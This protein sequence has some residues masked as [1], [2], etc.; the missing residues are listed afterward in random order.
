MIDNQNSPAPTV[1]PVNEY[2]YQVFCVNSPDPIIITDSGCRILYVNPAFV[3]LTGF[4]LREL[5]DCL[6]PFPFQVRDGTTN[7]GLLSAD[8]QSQSKEQIWKKKDGELIRVETNPVP[9][10]ENGV[11]KYV[12]CLWKDITERKTLK[13][14]LQVSEEKLSNMLNAIPIPIAIAA[15][16]SGIIE[17]VNKSFLKAGGYT[18]NEI[19][20]RSGNDLNWNDA[21]TH[22]RAVAKLMKK[23]HFEAE[24]IRLY[25]REGELR[26]SLLCA[27]IVEFGGKQYMLS[28][29]IDIT[30]RKKA[31]D[32]LVESESFNAGL[33]TNSPNPILVLNPDGSIRYANPALE[34]LTGFSC[35][36]LTGKTAP[37]PWWPPEKI[38]FY[39]EQN[40]LMPLGELERFERAYIKKNGERFWSVVSVCNVKQ[41][42]D[43]KYH[44]LNWVDITDRKK[45][46]DALRESEAFNAGL[47]TNSPN[48][49]LVLNPDG[50][51]RYANPALEAL[52]GFSSDEIKGFPPFPW[53]PAELQQFYSEDFG[54]SK[55][56]ETGIFERKYKKKNG[57]IFW[58]SVNVRHIKQNENFKYHIINWVDITEKKKTETALKESE[59]FGARLLHDA[60]NPILLADNIG[61][62]RYVNPALEHL[63]GFSAAELIGKTPPF[64]WWPRDKYE[65]YS[66]ERASDP[67]EIY[68]YRERVF[69]KKNGETFWAAISLQTIREEGRVKYL[70]SNWVDITERK[71]MEDRIVDLYLKEKLQREELQEEAK[72]RGLFINILAHELRTPV[73]PILVSIGLLKNNI[74]KNPERLQKKL[75]DNIFL[76]TNLLARRLEELLELGSYSRGNLKLQIKPVKLKQLI[77]AVIERYR[78]SLEQKKQSLSVILPEIEPV[79]DADTFR[80]EHVLVSLL[81]STSKFSPVGDILELSLKPQDNGFVISIRGSRMEISSEDQ[82]KLFMP[83]HRVE[84]D[85]QQFPGLGLELALT[86]FIIEAHGGKIW[87]NSEPGSGN[88]FS[89]F[90]PSR[91]EPTAKQEPLTR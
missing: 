62:I 61:K 72:A 90:I 30:D 76:S 13:T 7:E 58:C 68:S 83:Y 4:S 36:E 2:F 91:M 28:A 12:V 69:N 49:I 19:V 66:K 89:F 6:P 34:K 56:S 45:T 46:E 71:K 32:A 86:R 44:I 16:P 65:Q 10:E 64:P 75:V 48:P 47:L 80:L 81:T 20:G 73:T 26:T 22:D 67:A 11:L 31:E 14:E 70:L 84:Q 74:D 50:S 54:N 38:A 33:L 51:I 23:G 29:S 40:A 27:E 60:P 43:I 3:K 78:M 37:Y 77:E 55:D 88:V 79:I 18:T 41:A 17:Y 82:A 21:T 35:R 42:G 24:E 5:A 1:F 25:T 59:A 57:E 8:G 9:L 39:F 52:T 63:T 53:W 87:I 15:L 85:R